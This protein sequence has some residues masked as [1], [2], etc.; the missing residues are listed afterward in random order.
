[1]AGLAVVT[2]ARLRPVRTGAAE[3]AARV[4]DDLDELVTELGEAYRREIPEYAALSP[5]DLERTVLPTSRQAVSLYFESLRDGRPVSPREL[6]PTED[7]GR[8]RL[9]MGIPLE[10]VLRAYRVAGRLVWDAVVAAIRPGEEGLLA[11]L[12]RGWIDHIDAL[13]SVV[14]RSYLEASHSRLRAVDARRRELLEALLTAADPAEV[15]AVSLR[16]STVLAG[17]YIP[18][19]A[20]GNGAGEHIDA[21]LAAAPAGTLG[22]HRGDR[23]L[24]LVPTALPDGAA[25]HTASG[26]GLLAFGRPTPP[27]PA[28]LEE[29][30]HVEALLDAAIAEGHESGCYGPDDLLVEQLLLGNDRVSDALRRRVRDV[31]AARD[32]SGAILRTL[33][34]YLATGSVPETAKREVVHP[35]TVGYRL[36]RVRDLTGLEPRVPVDAV[37]LVLG[38]GLGGTRS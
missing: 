24:L 15:A 3:V 19:L 17:A 11:E 20:A 5:A 14:A 37:L 23:L 9:E 34:T 12:A 13:S 36:T 8:V 31:L 4:L 33:S 18:V 30:C 6:R 16:F 32:P 29:V 21:A 1:M 7:A 35:N 22:A 26:A 2:A 25:L 38:L 27:G 10:S 28:L